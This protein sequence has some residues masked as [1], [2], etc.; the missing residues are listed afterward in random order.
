MTDLCMNHAVQFILIKVY[1]VIHS[2]MLGNVGSCTSFKSI[3]DPGSSYQ[4]LQLEVIRIECKIRFLCCIFLMPYVVQRPPQMTLQRN[5]LSNFNIKTELMFDSF[6]IK[7]R[8]SMQESESLEIK[9]VKCAMFL[10]SQTPFCSE[11]LT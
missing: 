8:A 3:V 2:W 1:T 6:R 10:V 7:T 9:H 11:K 5:K 4:S